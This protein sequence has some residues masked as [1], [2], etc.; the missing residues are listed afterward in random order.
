MVKA[1]NEGPAALA[2]F[3]G[4][5]VRVGDSPVARLH[6]RKKDEYGQPSYMRR[7]R[8]IQLKYILRTG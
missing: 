1:M 7:S 8:K 6:W 2:C 3:E 5:A 4:A